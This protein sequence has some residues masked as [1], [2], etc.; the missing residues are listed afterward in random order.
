MDARTIVVSLASLTLAQ[1]GELHQAA[2]ECDADQMRQ[3]LSRSPSLNETDEDGRTPLL[4]AIDARQAE[5]VGLLLEAG[6]DPLARDRKG[7]NAFRATDEIADRRDRTAIRLYLVGNSVQDVSQD[8]TG[9]MPWSLEH[10]VMH[11]QTRATKMLLELG[12]DP[13]AAGRRGTTPLADAALKGNLEGVR[14]LL[15]AGA[16]VDAVSQAGAQPIH[17]AALGDNGEVV[18]ELV[19]RGADVNAR[20]RDEA[21]TPLHFAAAMGKVKAVEALVELGADL[22]VK[23]SKGR[24]P[25]DAAERA[26]RTDIA[27][28]LRRAAS[29]K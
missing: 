24:T 6:A 23:D 9:P 2:R 7:R 21:Q 20:T 22:T 3:L 4:I 12:A 18:R 17:S 27:A 28:F 11:G 19:M 15:D 1:A 25:L 10:S 16:R 5:C 14:L 8:A 26:G 13:N 29:A